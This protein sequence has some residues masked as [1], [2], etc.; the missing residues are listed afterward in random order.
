MGRSRGP[1]QVSVGRVLAIGRQLCEVLAYLHRQGVIHRDL[2]PE[3]ILVDPNDGIHIIDFGIA[4][5]LTARRLTWG[6]LS[7]CM[8]TPEYMAPEQIR[9]AR[10]DARA[11]VYALGLILYEWLGG[12]SPFVAENAVA[13]M[14][15]KCRSEPS[16]LAQAVRDLDPKVAAV[17]MRAIRRERRDRY[18]SAEEMLAALRDPSS[19]SPSGAP[20]R[21]RRRE[22]AYHGRALAH[23]GVLCAVLVALVGL[24]ALVR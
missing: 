3:N 6:R 24:V 5:D 18:A 4:L 21:A 10:G 9:G 1:G 8:G 14:K 16:P 11:D 22:A 7:T 2:K 20:V 13:M 23:V 17:V 19:A 15:V 12:G